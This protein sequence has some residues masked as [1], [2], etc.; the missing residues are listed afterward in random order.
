MSFVMFQDSVVSDGASVHGEDGGGLRTPAAGAAV[1][2]R[3]RL[4]VGSAAHFVHD[5]CLKETV[6][7]R[8]R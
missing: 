7:G 3:P 4:E 5:D 2:H 1:L 6:S 8:V